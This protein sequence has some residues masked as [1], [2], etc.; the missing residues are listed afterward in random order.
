MAHH[1][2]QDL[3]PARKNQQHHLLKFCFED[4]CFFVNGP[5]RVDVLHPNF[6][7]QVKCSYF[8]TL[9]LLRVAPQ[10]E[11]ISR[12]FNRHCTPHYDVQLLQTALQHSKYIYF[13]FHT[14][15]KHLTEPASKHF[16]V[17]GIWK[18]TDSFC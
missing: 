13:N 6:L 18:Y 7:A 11:S 2:S 9:V 8:C 15:E 10:S 14:F 16:R 12:L 3:Q 17:H 4:D 1:M 5:F